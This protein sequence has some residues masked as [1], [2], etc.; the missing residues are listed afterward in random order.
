MSDLK[1]YMILLGCKPKGRFTE[2]HDI[3]FGI[4]ENMAALKPAMREF[5]KDAGVLHI[6][7][8][9]EVNH[10]DGYKINVREKPVEA[11]LIKPKKLFFINLG[12]YKVNEFDEYHY[13]MITV[14]EDSGAAVR[15][16]KETA[17]YKHTGFKDAGSHVD[18]KYGVDVDD[19][20]NIREILSSQYTDKYHLEIIPSETSDQD[21]INLGYKM[22]EDCIDR[23][24]LP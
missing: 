2:Q 6:D 17:F 21:N 7:A 23:L 3:F 13:K 11:G 5:W 1:L 14:A 19:I 16:S 24:S 12:G 9:R 20:I 18:D 15:A 8:W 22:G 4:G 10:V